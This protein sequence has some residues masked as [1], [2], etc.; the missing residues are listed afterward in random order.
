MLLLKAKL[1]PGGN[2]GLL[3]QVQSREKA[4]PKA[5][6]PSMC[7]FIDSQYMGETSQ[8]SAIQFPGLG[9]FSDAVAAASHGVR[10]VADT[11]FLLLFLLLPDICTSSLQGGRLALA[12]RMGY[13]G[14]CS[15][16]LLVP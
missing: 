1:G 5:D 7:S 9:A 6:N 14:P 10:H 3:S 15:I 16:I 11:V 12:T 4:Y 8:L 13:A 2:D